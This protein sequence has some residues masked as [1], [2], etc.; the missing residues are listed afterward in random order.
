MKQLIWLAALAAGLALTGCEE[1]QG[2]DLETA[3]VPIEA[4]SAPAAEDRAVPATDPG[5]VTDALPADSPPLAPGDPSS[6]QTVRPESETLF[7]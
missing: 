5:A 2:A 7:Y 4:E 6:E 1:P 3:P